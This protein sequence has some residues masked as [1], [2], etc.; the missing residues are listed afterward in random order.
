M[1]GVIDADTHI[2]EHP[3]VW[4]LFDEELYHRRP[5]LASM[6]PEGPSDRQNSVWMIDGAAIPKRTG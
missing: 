2:I 6:D 5:K 3:G 1:P 4:E